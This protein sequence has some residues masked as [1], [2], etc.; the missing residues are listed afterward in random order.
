MFVGGWYQT[1]IRPFSVK[2]SISTCGTCDSAAGATK[3]YS[4]FF[5]VNGPSSQRT[6]PLNLAAKYK[7]DEKSTYQW[8]L[9]SN[10]LTQEKKLSTF[11]QPPTPLQLE[12]GRISITLCKL[13]MLADYS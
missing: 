2:R 11:E 8:I 7:V 3:T 9:R 13:K 4:I 6:G 1:R 10:E 12:H 5:I